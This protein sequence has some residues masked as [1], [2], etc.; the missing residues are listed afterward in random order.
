MEVNEINICLIKEKCYAIHISK[1]M[2]HLRVPVD[3]AGKVVV[4]VP[5]M[6]LLG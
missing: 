6:R 5:K 2:F 3:S 4:C 1:K